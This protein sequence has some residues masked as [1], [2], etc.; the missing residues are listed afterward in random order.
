MVGRRRGV[1][2]TESEP[3]FVATQGVV[4]LAFVA[5]GVLAAIRFRPE[6]EAGR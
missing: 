3:P 4:P 5:L 1:W 2:P 6:L